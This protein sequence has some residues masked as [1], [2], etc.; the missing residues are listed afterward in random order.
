VELFS[1]ATYPSRVLKPHEGIMVLFP[2]YLYH[3]TVPFKSDQRRICVAFD[4][5]PR[6]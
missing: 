1:K 3:G 4:V 5:I 6:R 2:A